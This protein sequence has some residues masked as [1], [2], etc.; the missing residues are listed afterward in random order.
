MVAALRA[1]RGEA[2]CKREKTKK[3]FLL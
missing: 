3:A 1:L 2:L